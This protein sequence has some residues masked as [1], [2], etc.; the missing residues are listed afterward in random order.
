M[1]VHDRLR[2]MELAFAL[3]LSQ[4]PPNLRL[5]QAGTRFKVARAIEVEGAT[6][7]QV[8]KTDVIVPIDIWNTELVKGDV[9][10]LCYDPPVQAS[11]HCSPIAEQYDDYEARC[12]RPDQRADPGYV[13]FAFSIS[14][15]Q[16]N[17]F[18]VWLPSSNQGDDLPVRTRALANF[19]RAAMEPGE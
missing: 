4:R 17:Q 15:V 1:S 5:P 18:F 11:T 14:Y 8:P 6:Y 2:A 12:V 13:G 9:V 7:I 3:E 10:R 16:L 19:L